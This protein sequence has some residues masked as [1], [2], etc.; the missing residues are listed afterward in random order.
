MFY[1]YTKSSSGGW[2]LSFAFFYELSI[3]PVELFI[4]EADWLSSDL[5]ELLLWVSLIPKLSY[6]KLLAKTILVML[7]PSVLLSI[8]IVLAC[9]YLPKS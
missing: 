2:K 6:Y 7:D 8:L 1:F 5:L 9:F 3:S 4:K